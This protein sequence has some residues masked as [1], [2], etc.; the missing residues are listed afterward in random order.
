VRAAVSAL[1]G[2]VGIDYDP[3]KDLFRVR[4]D[5]RQARLNDIFAA[6]YAAGRGAGQEYLPQ[7]VS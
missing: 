3:Q 4:F 5:A 2:V 7:V 6:V 1:R